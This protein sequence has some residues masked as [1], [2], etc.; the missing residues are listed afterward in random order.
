M[1]VSVSHATDEESEAAPAGASARRRD[2]TRDEP[3][4]ASRPLRTKSTRRRRLEAHAG[5][6]LHERCAQML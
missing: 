2:A 5:I 4:L 1:C 6:R 3:P